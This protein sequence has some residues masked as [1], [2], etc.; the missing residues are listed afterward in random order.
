MAR[1]EGAWK[2]E[3]ET[4]GRKLEF[5]LSKRDELPMDPGVEYKGTRESALESEQA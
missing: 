3:W 5:P 4:R 2:F 1:D